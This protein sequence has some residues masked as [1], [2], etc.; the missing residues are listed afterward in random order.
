MSET[1][2]TSAPILT[3]LGATGT[4]TGSRFLLEAGG[5]RLL[6]DCGLYQGE[7]HLRERNWAP[8]P[9]D[10][11]SIDAVV[12]THAHVDHCGYL[13]KIVRDGFAGPVYATAGTLGL[14]EIVLPDAGRLQEEE[15]EYANRRGYSRHRPALPLYTEDDAL[16]A[17][18]CLRG[19]AY[20]D[21]F[22][23]VPGVA[24]TFRSAGHILG[25]ASVVLDVEGGRRVVCSGDLGRP[26]HPLLLPPVP[27]PA[28]DVV[29][30]ESTYGDRS[31]DDDEATRAR[32]RDVI[33]RTVDR[34]GVVVVPAFAVDRTEVVLYHLRELVAAGEV[35]DVPVYVDSP[36]ALAALGLYR[37]AIAAGGD[38]EFRPGL[39]DGDGDDPFDPGRL[40]EA[41]S[42]ED[43]KAINDRSDPCVVVSASG[44]ATG[45]RVVHHLAR[46]LPDPRNTVL[47]VGFQAAGTRGRLLLDGAPAVK[48][49]G[50]YVQVR[51]EVVNVSGF[52]VHGDREDL[53]AWVGAAEREP[54]AVYTVHGEADACA[55]LAGAVRERLGWTAVVP[56][57]GERV[58]ID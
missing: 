12:L 47:L 55:A 9:I 15:A 18:R 10:P 6:V 11:A 35:P 14:A 39:A 22:E 56:S 40:V 52:S 23:A 49:L 54:D 34:G 48:M 1:P 42:V 21:T 27:P 19:V 4:V 43:S 50:R 31:H 45:G 20:G 29:L 17:L 41:R 36:M 46:R 5:R 51:A 2:V 7:K 13:P 32:F 30:V 44:M 38:D 33:V 3:F 24:V 26:N 28:A 58:R 25:S 53:L 8:F 16:L 37:R 57:H